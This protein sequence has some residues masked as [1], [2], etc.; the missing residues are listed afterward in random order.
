MTDRKD[1]E[2]LIRATDQS[3]STLASVAGNINSVTDALKK[4]IEAAASGDGAIDQLKSS[5]NDLKKA[6]DAIISQQRLIDSY[7]QQADKLDKLQTKAAATASAYTLFKNELEG[8][9]DVTVKQQASLD[10]L[11][12]SMNKAETA[13]AKQENALAATV[14]KLAS[15]GI[16]TNEL[17]EAQ[18]LLLN[19]AQQ[20]G[21]SMSA[22]NT[23]IESYTMNLRAAKEAASQAAQ[24]QKDIAAARE[25]E[26]QATKEA[27]AMEEQYQAALRDSRNQ[28]A[29]ETLTKLL[30]ER[31]A[32][33]K[34]AAAA[35]AATTKADEAAAA[36]SARRSAE[37]EKAQAEFDKQHQAARQMVQ[38]AEYVKLFADTLD[39]ADAQEEAFGMNRAFDEKAARDLANFQKLADAAKMAANGY[40]T[41]GTASAGSGGTADNLRAI[42]DPTGVQRSTVSGLE[43]QAAGLAQVAAASNG[44]LTE[45]TETVKQLQ[46]VMKQTVNIGESIDA[47]R[48]QVAAVNAARAAFV[49]ARSEVQ[50]YAEAIKAADAPDQSLADGLKRAQAAMNSTQR[51]MQ[52]T[53]ESAREMQAALQAAGVATNELDAEEARLASVAR[54]TTGALNQLNAAYREHGSA[55][56]AATK[57]IKLFGEGQ[58]ESLSLFQRLRG[59]VLGLA[60]A[61]VGIQGAIGLAGSAL[62]AFVD[63]QAVENR[64]GVVLGGPDP[65]AIAQEY[66]YLHDEAERLG[67]G[68]KELADSYSRFALAS[69]NANLNLDQ[70]KYAFERITEAMRVNHSS[71]DAINGAFNQLEQ[72]L[73]KNKVQMD[74][75]RQASNWIP[76]LEGMLARGLGMVS[77]KQLFDGMQK[78]AI[79]AKTAILGLAQ[80]MERTYSKQLPDSLKSLQA[81]QGRF[82]TSLNDFQ[83]TIAESGF[84][85]AYISLLQK[86]NTFFEGADGKNYA[87]QLSDAFS[88]VVSVLKLVVDN[89]G[90]VQAGF[91]LWVESKTISWLIGLVS[92]LQ[93][94]VK[95]SADA[96]AQQQAL[97]AANSEAGAAASAAAVANDT[98]NTA[99]AGAAVSARVLFTA[100]GLVKGALFGIQGAIIGWDI[101]KALDEKFD[102]VHKW[103]SLVVEEFAYSWDMVKFGFGQMIDGLVTKAATLPARVG[104]AIKELAASTLDA[105]APEAAAQ[106]RATKSNVDTSGG[107]STDAQRQFAL[108]NQ[109]HDQNMASINSHGGYSNDGRALT[110]AEQEA[111]L[112]A[113]Q[114]ADPDGYNMRI[115]ALGKIKD[116]EQ[117]INDLINERS[118]ALTDIIKQ[119]DAHTIT[120]KQAEEQSTATFASYG[121]KFKQLAADSEK[122]IKPLIDAL[123]LKAPLKELQEYQSKLQGAVGVYQPNLTGDTKDKN[124]SRRDSMAESLQNQLDSV[125]AK[126][127]TGNNKGGADTFEQQL[128]VSADAIDLQYDRIIQKVKDFQKIG[129]TSIGG[130]STASYLGDLDAAKEQVKQAAALKIEL[131]DIKKGEDDVNNV[132]KQRTDLYKDLED[133]VKNGDLGGA[134]A[135]AAANDQASKLNAQITDLVKKGI[136]FNNSMRGR[137]GIDNTKIDLANQQLTS[138]GRQAGT[139]AS[140]A[141][142]TFSN[143][144]VSDEEKKVNDILKARADLTQQYVNLEKV[145]VVTTD[146]AQKKIQQDYADTNDALNKNIDD[147]Q[148]AVDAAH[149]NGT[150]TGSNYDLAL[151]KIKEFRSEVQYVNPDLAKLKETFQQTFTG[152]VVQGADDFAETL[153]N[154]IDGTEKLSDSW[155]DFGKDIANIFASFLKSIA[156]AIIQIQAM[157][158][159]Q[160]VTSAASDS[161]VGS[162]FSGLFSTVAGAVTSHAGSVVGGNATTTRSNV[163]MSIFANAPRYHSGTNGPLGLKADEHA[164]I[165]QT[166]EEVL[167]RNNPRN[168]LN[169]GGNSGASGSTQGIRQVLAI[170]DNEVAKAMAGSA[171]E[172]TV[173]THLKAN[174]ATVRQ[175]VK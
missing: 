122:A 158:V 32:A 19:S 35:T 12:D 167:S 151:A 30:E 149:A 106:I 136:D 154:L 145:G 126:G 56:D 47:F 80:E 148:K 46:A 111:A 20:V 144:V 59:E 110:G 25:A 14:E 78:G 55:S 11:A 112:A 133:R 140:G 79:D 172:T 94:M 143:S 48:G 83:R 96:A 146:E 34:A 142:A 124:A 54:T 161:G 97:A 1:V 5:L 51:E 127:M 152:S 66:S 114:A 100:L 166:G 40:K 2:L 75:L 85:N 13:V 16:Y 101:G 147:L 69:K 119:R 93:D 175:W 103:S 17:N 109:R 62:E 18:K 138:I 163:P 169:G 164:A 37:M 65:K 7:Q 9:T 141:N 42:T 157:K 39:L 58:R 27:A 99:M 90:L 26:A 116:G 129:G 71:T 21:V 102:S 159:A 76:G 137:P 171:G 70:T 28:G 4:Q 6:G 91:M 22:A 98:N 38:D 64:L 44:P 15:A 120:E 82:T 23:S 130:K 77:V 132:V 61:Y 150:L 162:F 113:Q 33:E 95:A 134:D 31:E 49:E 92:S 72:M 160:S 108:I 50:R 88:G 63:K 168:V 104:N 135:I 89:I 139:A 115:Q 173:M 81:E 118:K 60:A 41:F 123:G 36:A 86:L 24:V 156:N 29:V 128:K 53:V 84:A 45:Y 74:D 125:L 165:L 68:I 121:P 52:Q 43:S 117:A 3:K 153:A 87:K 155:K 105:T 57:S 107:M 131:D 73:S 10:R 8:A 170:G 67:I 174:I